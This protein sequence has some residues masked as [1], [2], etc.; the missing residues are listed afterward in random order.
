MFALKFY[1]EFG[2]NHPVFRSTLEKIVSNPSH[3]NYKKAIAM[4][5][6]M[7]GFWSYFKN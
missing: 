2:R 6:D 3:N 7:Y 4:E 1:L 5:E